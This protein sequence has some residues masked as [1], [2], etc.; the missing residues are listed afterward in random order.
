MSNI[1]FFGTETYSVIALEALWRAGFSIR[2]IVTKPDA[3]RGRGKKPT[4]PAVKQFA[5]NHGIP[6][7]QPAT[8][9]EIIPAITA[10]D[11]PVGVLVAYGKII[12]ESI[13]GLFTPGIINIHPSL[14]PLYRGPSPVESAI[15]NQDSKT[16]VTIMKLEKAMDAGPIYLQAPYALDHSETKP[17]LYTTLFTLGANLLTT[18]LPT[19]I[20]GKRKPIPQN[21]NLATYCHL[22][23]KSDGELHPQNVTASQAEAQIRAH[24]HYPRTRLSIGSHSIIATKAHVTHEQKT[25]LDIACKNSTFLSIDELI[26]PSGNTM[27][28]AA[29]LRGYSI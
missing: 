16:G 8:L 28:A 9:N 7:L 25:L 22:L 14:L 17:E 19:I 13:I 10:L 6:V 15:I 21:E 18:E 27:S 23:T 1:V 3:P 11:S 29:F 26:A 5:L 2:L 12:P 24:I 20:S 4:A